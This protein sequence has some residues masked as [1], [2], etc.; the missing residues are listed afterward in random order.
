MLKLT[1]PQGSLVSKTKSKLTFK[2]L[3]G[4][5]DDQI[6]NFIILNNE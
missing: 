3:L 2:I 1:L 4:G 5:K 6:Q